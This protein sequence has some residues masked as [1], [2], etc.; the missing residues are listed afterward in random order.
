M[1]YFVFVS[2]VFNKKNKKKKK[3][4][5]ACVQKDWGELSLFAI[6]VTHE[7][8]GWQRKKLLGN[9]KNCS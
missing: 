6:W 3:K 1:L 9:V 2:N 5:F 8:L 7:S 4:T